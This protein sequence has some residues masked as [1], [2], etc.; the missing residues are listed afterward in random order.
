[1]SFIPNLIAIRWWARDLWTFPNFI[2]FLHHS[3]QS[4]SYVL[5]R[6]FHFHFLNVPCETP[7]ETQRIWP[8]SDIH[9]ILLLFAVSGI[10]FPIN[11]LQL[12][13]RE[14]AEPALFS[15]FSHRTFTYHP[16]VKTLATLAT[17]IFHVRSHKH[18]H[19]DW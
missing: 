9:N 7:G 10:A 12:Y 1:M 6:F 11:F 2:A 13:S 14:L 19:N 5:T 16:N 15:H 8:K 4:L 17:P 3:D 18:T